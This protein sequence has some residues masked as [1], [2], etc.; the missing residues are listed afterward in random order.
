M[1]LV[2]GNCAGAFSTI[3]KFLSWELISDISKNNISLYYH[4]ANKTDFN[5][6]TFCNLHKLKREE[7]DH[8]F[9]IRDNLMSHFFNY[10]Q[11]FSENFEEYVESFPH[12]SLDLIK[13][14]P[15]FLIQYHGGG[16]HINLYSDKDN[17]NLIRNLY[18]NYWKKFSLQQRILDRVE[19]ESNIIKNQKVLTVMIRCA[20]HYPGADMS[21]KSFLD[22]AKKKMD[23]YDKILVV[24]LVKPYLDLFYE[25]FGNR[26]VFLNRERVTD[27]N[28]DWKGGRGIIMSND[29]YIKEVEDCIVDTLIASKTDHI[30]GGAS[31]MFLG[32]LC[33]NPNVTFD[34][35]TNLKNINGT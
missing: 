25:T 9:V 16:C 8:Q 34:I 33:I 27:E 4:W 28:D 26:C 31:N 14:C 5:G 21:V 10:D 17:L 20:P 12:S 1:N 18:H 2:I 13:V 11:S 3:L 30:I 22:D 19:A 15:D 29:E 24:T 6:N 35:F 32:A 23:D 7:I